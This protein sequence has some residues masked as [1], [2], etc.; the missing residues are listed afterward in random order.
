MTAL[1]VVQSAAV[2]LDLEQPSTLYSNTDRTWVEAGVMLNTCARQILEEYDW[3]RLIKTA[4]VTGDDVTTSFS[5]PADYDRMVKDSNLWGTS[6]TFYPAQQIQDFNYWLEL[7]SYSVE[8]WEPRWS[9]F[10][11]NLNVM[12]AIADGEVLRYGYISNAIVNGA[13]TSQFTADTDTFVLD[14]RL[15]RLSFIWNWKKAKGYDFQAE[16]AEY[17]AAMQMA[18]FKDPGSRQ[19]ISSGRGQYR[20][21]TGQTFP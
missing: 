4:A 12:P 13:D 8:T 11:G 6:Y 1:S 2:V 5:L 20:Y 19:S 15:L 17:T 14:E 7:Q 21:P 3:Q 16:A 18:R 9:L 10:G